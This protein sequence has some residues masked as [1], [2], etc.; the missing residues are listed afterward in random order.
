MRIDKLPAACIQLRSGLDIA[1]NLR[2]L[3]EMLRRAASEGAR[4]VLTPENTTI[5]D[6]DKERVRALAGTMK[7]DEAV[8][9]LSD[10]AVEYELFL[11]VGS[12]PLR[13]ETPGEKRL[14]NRSIL[15]APD[16]HA[17]ATYDKIHLFDVD[18]GVE[19]HRESAH[20]R[21]G[22]EAVLGNVHDVRIGLS[23]CY[24]VRFPAL[25]R[26]LAHAGAQIF[27]IPA[28]FTVPTGRA[29]WHVL[30][31]ARAIENGAYV[32]AA[33]QGGEHESGRSTFGHS[34]VVS[35]WGEVLAEAGEEP[36]VLP[37]TLDMARV[38][39]ARR[40]IPVL[41]HERAFRKPRTLRLVQG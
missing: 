28:A 9:A 17:I 38:A 39:E 14:V 25:Y 35:P 16:G 30:V 23:I 20:V 22:Q 34:L 3:R 5:M 33:A 13:S 15:F 8:R 32:L 36:E 18:I 21:P 1:T 2:V 31:R 12:L 37:V 10:M 29:H 27:A 41:Q 6:E 19:R 24:D 26:A 11:H 7:E 4:Y 40:R